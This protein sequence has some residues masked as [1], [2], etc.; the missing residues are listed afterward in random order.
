MDAVIMAGGE[1][2]RLKSVTGDTPKPMALLC[3][4]PILEHILLLLK[5]NGITNVC[6]SLRYRPEAIISYFGSGKSL[7][8]NIRYNI[9][10]RPLGTAGGVKACLNHSFSDSFLVISGDCACDFD[11]RR[12]MAA[13]MVRNNA[14]TMA[15]FPCASPLRFGTV[16]TDVSGRIVSFTE[17]PNWS[18]VVSDLVNTGIY[19][20]DRKVMSHVPDG[21]PFDFSKELFPLLMS[22]GYSLGGIVMK[23]YWC[24]IGTPRE[25]HSCNLDALDG[26]LNLS[27][28]IIPLPQPHPTPTV[29]SGIWREVPCADRARLMRA[30]SQ[31]LME[32][33]ADFTNG[34][35]LSQ[36]GDQIHIFPSENSSS[37]HINICG[38]AYSHPEKTADIYE[39]LAKKLSEEPTP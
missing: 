26:K 4:K 3:G 35:T 39:K 29:K 14:V 31:N 21:K 25:Y 8:M 11:L 23:G 37:I 32:A 33:G 38:N 12:L 1:G 18:R 15:L 19:I 24:D 2:T 7:G 30:M 17:K 16:L 34:I 27:Q 10:D 36:N 5:Q 22:K 6:I 20:I 13:H 28:Q 9:E